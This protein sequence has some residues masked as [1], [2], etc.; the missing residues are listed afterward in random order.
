MKRFLPA[1]GKVLPVVFLQIIGNMPAAPAGCGKYI[2]FY[3]KD[4]KEI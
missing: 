2:G 4:E 1:A 3:G